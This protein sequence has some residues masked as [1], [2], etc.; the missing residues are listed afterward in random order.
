[1]IY[2]NP[3]GL[4]PF[5]PEVRE[6]IIRTLDTFSHMLYTEA[7]IQ[8]Y[9][10]TLQ[11]CRRTIADCLALND[12][13]RVAFMPNTTTACSLTLSRI[14]WRTGDILLTTAHENSTILQ[15]IKEL[16]IQGV[17]IISLDPDSPAGL[18]LQIE[19]AVHTRSVRAIVVS[20]V[21]HFDGR[22]FPI[23]AIQ[24]LAQSH[25]ALLIVDGA[26][27]VGHIPV[28]FQQLRPHAY[29]FPG[30][31]WCAGPMGTGALIL[32]EKCG[33]TTARQNEEKD[34]QQK[35]RPD[36]TRYELGTQNIGLIAGLAKACDKKRHA[37]MNGQILD[38]IR[39]EWKDR[40]GYYS[41]IRIIE[42]DGPHAPGILSFACLDE[43]AEQCIQTVSSTH[44]IAWKTFTHPSYPSRLSVRVSWNATTPKTALHSVL[45][46]LKIP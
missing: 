34:C 21:S 10:K 8:H 5:D 26:Q 12:E 24:N 15:E 36:W 43:Q 35:T 44:S 9:R 6:E 46:F 41:G 14:Q 30:H 2:L 1:M 39:E 4:S 40:L 45:D 18:L 3:A 29:F 28:T 22:I 13:Q 7:G 20:H 17:E 32:D 25:Q 38:K 42:W 16:E 37:G 23:A 31:K 27:A 19:T 33:E 11:R